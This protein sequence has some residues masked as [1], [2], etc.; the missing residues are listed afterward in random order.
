MVTPLR[1]IYFSSL[2]QE[3]GYATQPKQLYFKFIYEYNNFVNLSFISK[4][5]AL[6]VFLEPDETILK[7]KGNVLHKNTAGIQGLHYASLSLKEIGTVHTLYKDNYLN[8][9][10]AIKSPLDLSI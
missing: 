2:L 8:F 7:I 3:R 10:I 1:L 4:Q 6:H 5:K 9:S